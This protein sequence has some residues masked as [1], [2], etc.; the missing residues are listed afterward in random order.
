VIPE[1]AIAEAVI[2]GSGTS[3]GVPMLGYEYPEGYLDEPKNHRMR[4]CLALLGPSG[5]VVVDCP[6]EF[7]IQATRAGLMDIEAVIVTH[8][9]ADHV[10]GM[11][12][13]RSIC[14]KTG[15][16]MPVYTLPEYQPDI[17]RIF[18]YA[19]S[20]PPPGVAVPRFTFPELTDP[21]HLGGM[22]IRPFV[23]EHGPSPCLGVRVGDFAYITDVKRIPEPAMDVIRGCRTFVVDAVRMRPHPNHFNL[24]EALAMAE[25]VG[26]DSTYL[27]H[28]SHDYDHYPSEARMP[29][30]VYLAYD[31]LRIAIKS[32]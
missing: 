31:G 13:L 19:F 28:L 23:V 30:G 27:T 16:E 20:E 18:P 10:M 17:R 7:R 9:H 32:S 3:N 2:L 25:A 21:L 8:T 11:D 12:D 5:N 15:R 26:A 29:P 6:P 22:E 4:S 14:I 1:G 24:E